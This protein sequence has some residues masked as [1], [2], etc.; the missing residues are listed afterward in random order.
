MF[1]IFINVFGTDR[2]AKL[3]PDGAGSAQKGD[4]FCDFGAQ[5]D[6]FRRLEVPK[7]GARG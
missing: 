4:F 5:S 2:D 6:E 3:G 1:A 7:I